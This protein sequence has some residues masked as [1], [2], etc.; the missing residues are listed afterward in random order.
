MS[1]IGKV[2]MIPTVLAEGSQEQTL[3]TEIAKKVNELNIFAVE[4]I[5]SARRFIRSVDKEKVID[6][7]DFQI[8]DKNSKPEAIEEIIQKL[9]LG[10]DVG[11]LSEAGCPGIA[12]PGAK[13]VE[14]AHENGIKVIPLVGPSSILL[15]LMASGMNGQSFTFHGY[16]PIQD[17]ERKQQIKDLERRSIQ[18]DQ[19]QIFMETPYRNGKLLED[20]IKICSPK[21]KLCVACNIT[22]ADEYIETLTLG[23]WKNMK[24]DLHKK[25]TMFVLGK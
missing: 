23:D 20:L 9:Y 19:T 7:I 14:K 10:N 1:S 3:P 4:N 12:D 2:Y 17:R 11:V 16:L 21:T 6:E 22:G 13:L 25:P 15:A 18:N 24:V 8:L 5:R